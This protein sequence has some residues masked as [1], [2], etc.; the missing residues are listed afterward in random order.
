MGIRTEASD[1]ATAAMTASGNATAAATAAMDARENIATQQTSG[2]SGMLAYAA[3]DAATMASAAATA[4]MTAS[5]D[6]AAATDI[7]AATVAKIKAETAQAMA[8]TQAT[9][10]MT[11]RDAVLEAVKSELFIDVKTKTVGG[12]SLTI[13]GQSGTQIINGKTVTT[14]LMKTMNPTT[15]APAAAGSTGAGNATPPTLLRP[16][17]GALADLEIGF[18]YDSSDD[19]VRLML[20]TSYAGSKKVN[21][22][23]R[24]A[25]GSTLTGTKAGLLSLDDD[26]E[27]TTVHVNNVR[28]RSE[29]RYYRA[30]GDG[31]ATLTDQVNVMA[32]ATAVEVF[33]YVNPAGTPRE[34]VVLTETST[35][36]VETTYTYTDANILFDHDGDVAD[37]ADA[38]AETKIQV[39]LPQKTDYEHIHF[40]VWAGLGSADE[41]G[42]QDLDDLGIAFV[43]NY[44]GM[45]ETAVMPNH[46]MAEYKG[47][48]AAAVQGSASDGNGDISFQDGKASM[49]ANFGLG[50]VTATLT[51]L[52]TLEGDIA[53]SRFGGDEATVMTGDHSLNSAGEYTG[54]FMGAFY[55]TLASEAGGVFDFGSEDNEDG[56]FRGA[57]GGG[58]E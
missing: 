16:G 9:A 29:G 40:G 55:G 25:D 24:G 27:E 4:A 49:S 18:V 37:S 22:F 11:K 42:L 39:S 56:A 17:V 8:E 36:G 57:F 10:A 41:E 50:K 34:Y 54:E 30:G 20:V 51:G 52:A 12:T 53:G 32:T 35:K 43:Q 47:N 45:G 6:A 5:D 23:T 48:W 15:T 3:R 38:T 13:D 19:K 1:A 28:L 21:V 46:G 58:K 26:N 31:D 7:G 2:M 33:S 14:G 44:S